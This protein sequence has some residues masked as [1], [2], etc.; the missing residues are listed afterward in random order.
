MRTTN[1]KLVSRKNRKSNSLASCTALVLLLPA[2]AL[3][4]PAP[5]AMTR[6]N[7]L[8]PENAKIEQ[9]VGLWDVTETVWASPGATPVTTTGL[10]AERR[11]MGQL[12]QELIRPLT[13]NSHR[14][15]KRTELLSFNRVEG[16][17]AAC[18]GWHR[19][20]RISS[21]SRCLPLAWTGR[22]VFSRSDRGHLV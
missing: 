18:R 15:I 11:M 16:S 9:R 12:F 1:V 2:V 8:G 17:R 20:A 13:D 10:V 22:R 6:L 5:L 14:E 7:D 3:A 4:E 21:P 19:I